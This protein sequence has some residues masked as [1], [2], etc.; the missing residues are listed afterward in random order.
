MIIDEAMVEVRSFAR[1]RHWRLGEI[2]LV[3]PET[4]AVGIKAYCAVQ[5]AVCSHLAIAMVAVEW[6]FGGIDRDMVEIDTEPVALGVAVGEQS[7]LKHLVGRKADAWHNVGWRKGGLF[8]LGEIVL[9]VMVQLHHADLDQRILPF[10]PDLGK[11]ERVM[12]VGLGLRVGHHL[13]AHCPAR[14]VARLDRVEEVAAVA[15]SIL[16]YNGLSLG[17]SE[18][19]DALL[20]AEMKLDPDALISGIDH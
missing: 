1:K 11:V 9:R 8:H 6:A 13:N 16:G 17:V 4:R 20:R 19:L 14:E 12:P 15:F 3:I 2:G 18:I 10:R 7:G 5:I